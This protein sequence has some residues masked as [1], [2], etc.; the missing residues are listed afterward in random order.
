MRL[1][2]SRPWTW[3]H[4]STLLSLPCTRCGHSTQASWSCPAEPWAASPEG[5]HPAGAIA[6]DSPARGALAL[7]HHACEPCGVSG[8]SQFWDVTATQE[9]QEQSESRWSWAGHVPSE[10]TCS[11]KYRPGAASTARL[12]RCGHTDP[13][14]VVPLSCFKPGHMLGDWA[15]RSVWAWACLI[16]PTGEAEQM[17]MLLGWESWWGQLPLPGPAQ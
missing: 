17:V 9:A 7:A 6:P 14:A 12:T 1:T 5:R 15:K 3:R 16:P 11:D 10:C 2:S 8:P 4:A 13:K